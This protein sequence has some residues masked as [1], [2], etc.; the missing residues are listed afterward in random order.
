MGRTSSQ[1]AG[2]R[3]QTCT[4][5]KSFHGEQ[6]KGLGI[7]CSFSSPLP[8][9]LPGRGFLSSPGEPGGTPKGRV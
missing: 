7:V 6:E 2:I 3:F 1:T 5:V 8:P 4:P 9:G